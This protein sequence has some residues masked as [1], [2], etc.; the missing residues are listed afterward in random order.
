MA[1]LDETGL[2]EVATR[3][4]AKY[5]PKTDPMF[6][7]SLASTM[8]SIDATTTPSSDSWPSIHGI[9]DK[10]GKMCG[11]LEFANY[12]NGYLTTT[13]FARKWS[14]ST[15]KTNALYVGVNV[16][17]GCYYKVNDRSAFRYAIGVTSGQSLPTNVVA[18]DIFVRY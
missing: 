1:F 8:T 14:G 10:N 17:G 16:N 3:I 13:L 9:Y 6:I 2:K 5:A 4:A 12:A 11:A 7:G 15:S 18:G